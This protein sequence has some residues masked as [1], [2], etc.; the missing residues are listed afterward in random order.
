MLVTLEIL[1]PALLKKTLLRDP[2]LKSFPQSQRSIHSSSI[3]ALW[4]LRWCSSWTT[5]MVYPLC[6]WE[7]WRV[8]R[9][10]VSVFVCMVALTALLCTSTKAS[11]SAPSK[12]CEK[13]SWGLSWWVI[14]SGLSCKETLSFSLALMNSS[15]IHWSFCDGLSSIHFMFG[16]RDTNSPLGWCLDDVEI[17]GCSP[18]VILSG[19]CLRDDL[20]PLAE[21][22]GAQDR[23][24]V[25]E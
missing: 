15:H 14:S 10:K 1:P 12:P 22:W 17:S 2:S 9:W 8:Q 6:C 16:T 19:D 18:N 23:D 5:L 25:V 11:L 20:K 13:W 24:L 21:T 4:S 7:I 3:W